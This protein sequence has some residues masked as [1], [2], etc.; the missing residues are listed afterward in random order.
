MT[1]ISVAIKPSLLCRP[2]FSLSCLPISSLCYTPVFPLSH[3]ISI[4]MSAAAPYFDLLP[5]SETDPVMA[6][7]CKYFEL[8]QD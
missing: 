8:L 7:F 4:F 3:I 5:C 6:C 2:I 1:L